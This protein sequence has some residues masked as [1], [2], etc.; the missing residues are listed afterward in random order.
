MTKDW[1]KILG[2]NYK[3]IEDRIW[4]NEIDNTKGRILCKL[5]KDKDK[6]REN[7]KRQV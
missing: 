3:E 5:W 4:N 7:R 2:R 1:F 6:I